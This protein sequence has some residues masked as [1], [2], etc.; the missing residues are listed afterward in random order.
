MLGV[1]FMNKELRKAIMTWTRRNKCSKDIS[2]ANLFTSKRQGNVCVNP[3]VSNA[4][5][6]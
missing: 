3:F 1:T 4:P 5:F 6:L 2:A